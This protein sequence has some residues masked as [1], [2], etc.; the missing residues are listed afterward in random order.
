MITQPTSLALGSPDRDD[1]HLE[2]PHISM[3]V[4]GARGAGKH[5]AGAAPS[6]VSASGQ[7]RSS[8]RQTLTVGHVIDG[9]RPSKDD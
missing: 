3:R 8:R 2:N 5:P 1:G 6:P 4:S 9:D 7:T